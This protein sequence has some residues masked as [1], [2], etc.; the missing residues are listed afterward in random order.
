MDE[1][2]DILELVT[3]FLSDSQNSVN[4]V[5][6]IPC[7]E[8]Y[9]KESGFPLIGVM[10]GGD[11]L[12]EGAS[13]SLEKHLVFVVCY[14]QV[15]GDRSACVKSVR[16]KGRESRQLLENS[17]KFESG[18][19]LDEFNSVSYKRS[20]NARVLEET[21]EEYTCFKTHVFEFRRRVVTL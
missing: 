20:D 1:E 13:E 14:D 16:A 12:D 7:V 2:S 6:I 19:A 15:T 11:I 5:E 10:D 9:P 3:T 4:T 18:G 8:L 17:A 21:E